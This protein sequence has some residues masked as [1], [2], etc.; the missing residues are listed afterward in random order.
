MDPESL[1]LPD[2]GTAYAN[3]INRPSPTTLS[4]GVRFLEPN[5][6]AG[7]PRESGP[8][9]HEAELAD[10]HE[11]LPNPQPCPNSV[12]R[13]S[14]YSPPRASTSHYHP[15]RRDDSMKPKLEDDYDSD[16]K[17]VIRRSKL[18]GRRKYLG[19]SYDD[20]IK[21]FA[22]ARDGSVAFGRR[23]K[24]VGTEP[25]EILHT[26]A[27]A[28]KKTKREKEL[29]LDQQSSSD[30]NSDDGRYAREG[31]KLDSYINQPIMPLKKE[32]EFKFSINP[33]PAAMS[34]DAIRQRLIKIVDAF[35][36]AIY[37]QPIKVFPE[38]I[39]YDDW[40]HYSYVVGHGKWSAS[41]MDLPPQ[42]SR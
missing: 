22:R 10:S 16:R 35:G 14:D 19:P 15:T 33:R 1:P 41:D 28:S 34:V 9:S 23:K 42:A 39:A 27:R 13:E 25:I 37:Q 29:E 4:K 21:P 8:P 20:D 36:P 6:T 32:E 38:V 11:S 2:K 31:S 24:P 17:P 40:A 26:G 12:K 18:S 30:T 3:L 7:R 5:G